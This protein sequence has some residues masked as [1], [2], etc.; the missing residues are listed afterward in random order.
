MLHEH[1]T[2]QDVIIVLIVV[3]GVELIARFVAGKLLDLGYFTVQTLF[4]VNKRYA[5]NISISFF[6][7]LNFGLRP[8]VSLFVS[9]L[10]AVCR[11]KHFGWR[12]RGLANGILWSA[13][14]ISIIVN[15]TMYRQL[16]DKYGIDGAMMNV[17]IFKNRAS[18]P[19][20]IIKMEPL[21][22]WSYCSVYDY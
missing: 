12:N 8:F 13:S 16:I 4:V 20:V 17:I 2:K 18:S 19:K 1:F 5:L 21:W 10:T 6:R 3:G 15:P 7:M 9:S 11:L 14:G 22:S